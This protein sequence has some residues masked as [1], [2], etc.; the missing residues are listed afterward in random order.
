MRE[1]LAF[2]C[3]ARNKSF[4]KAA[5]EMSIT[6]GAI[7]KA[8]TA[9]ENFLELSLFKR[10]ASRIELTVAGQN[11]LAAVFPLISSLEAATLAVKSNRGTQVRLTIASMPSFVERCLLPKFGDVPWSGV[12]A[13]AARRPSSIFA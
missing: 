4:T 10:N 6:Q 9:L 12:G 7:S 1:L 5:Q 11:Y 2:E 3:A 13:D 8:I